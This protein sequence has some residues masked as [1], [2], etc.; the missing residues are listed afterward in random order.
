MRWMGRAAKGDFSRGAVD[1]TESKAISFEL[2]HETL[3]GDVATFVWRG[4]VV[5]HR[6]MWKRN[7]LPKL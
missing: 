7:G 2:V 4:D 3:D 1:I 6:A 5:V